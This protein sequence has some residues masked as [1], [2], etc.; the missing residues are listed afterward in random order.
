MFRVNNEN[1]R[2]TS[3]TLFRYFFVVNFEQ[4]LAELF[5]SFFTPGAENYGK[6]VK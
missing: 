3:V 5:S 1:N 2:T 4:L 6:P